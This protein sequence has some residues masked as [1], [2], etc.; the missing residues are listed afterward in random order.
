MNDR[1]FGAL[2]GAH[3]TAGNVLEALAAGQVENLDIHHGTRH[4]TVTVSFGAPVEAGVLFAAERELTTALGVTAVI[5]PRFAADRLSAEGLPSLVEHLKRLNAAVNGTF[6]DAVYTL[7]GDDLHIEFVHGG[8]N[9]LE[10]TN[11]KSQLATLIRNQYGRRVNITFV[12]EE[13]PQID[14]R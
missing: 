1:S 14:E 11:A 2:F 5:A 9:I 7:D 3:L 4:L 13:T 6:T 10:T 8:V 12:G